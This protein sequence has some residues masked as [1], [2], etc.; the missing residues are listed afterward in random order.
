MR[1]GISR[2]IVVGIVAAVFL[3]ALITPQIAGAAAEANKDVRVVN[4]ASEPVPVT[5]TVSIGNTPSVNVGNTPTVNVGNSPTVNVGNVPAVTLADPDGARVRSADQT[6]VVL[7]DNWEHDG[8]FLAYERGAFVDN[9]KTVRWLVSRVGVCSTDVEY[10]VS[11]NLSF[12]AGRT[13]VIDEG[14][15]PAS[16]V[17]T[18]IVELPGNILRFLIRGGTAES[19]CSG[20]VIAVGRRN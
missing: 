18:G 9:Y 6:Q 11:S 2:T 16:G 17:R 1:G 3:G 10:V 12:G 15:L 20:V 8:S 14:V 13:F 4:T 19:P 7:E 5:G